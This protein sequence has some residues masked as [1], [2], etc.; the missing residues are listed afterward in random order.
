MKRIVIL[1]NS[2]A[3]VKAI[4]EIRSADASSEITLITFEAYYPYNREAFPSLIARE[5]LGDQVLY[6]PKKF[7]DTHRVNVLR[8]KKISK[9]NLR[10]NKIF[11]EEKECVD[12]DDLLLTD[13]PVHKFPD[14]KGTH[15]SGVFGMKR[16]ND[17]N[18]ILEVLPLIDAVVIQSDEFIGLQMAAALVKRGKEVILILSENNLIESLLESGTARWLF[19]DLEAKG[20][21]ILRENAIAEILGEGDVKAVRLRSGKVIATQMVIFGQTCPDF[22]ILAESDLRIQQRI[23]VDAKFQTSLPHV[24]AVDQVCEREDSLKR[25][26]F[27]QGQGMEGDSGLKMFYQDMSHFAFQEADGKSVGAAINGQDIKWE[28]PI[29]VSS[30]NF[31]DLSVTIL[32]ALKTNQIME[33]NQLSLEKGRQY[34]NIWF[35]QD[36]LVGGIF[37]NT[38]QEINKFAGLMKDKISLKGLEQYV[39]DENVDYQGVVQEIDKRTAFAGIGDREN[40]DGMPDMGHVINQST[41]EA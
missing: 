3:G 2:V 11:T 16:L 20:M 25:L 7:Y 13:L 40:G 24:F 10:K 17:I 5:I 23:C 27:T 26:A 30:L 32:G 1:G 37:I 21:R 18:R 19:A 8:D 29:P 41:H 36:F 33:R 22:R 9:I 15:K 14:I 34:K 4:E 28:W 12:F 6:K 35:H 38:N 39:M 31:G